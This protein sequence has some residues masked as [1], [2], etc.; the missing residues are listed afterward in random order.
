MQIN[1]SFVSYLNAKLGAREG[2]RRYHQPA[3][4]E[5]NAENSNIV[6]EDKKIFAF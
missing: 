3:I 1:T 6:V 4:R 5:I 2:Y